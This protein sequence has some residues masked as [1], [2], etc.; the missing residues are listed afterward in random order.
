[1]NKRLLAVGGVL[2]LAL[3]VVWLARTPAHAHCDTLDG[4]VI[5]DA[6]IALEKGDVTSVLKWV[7]HANE[8]EIRAAFAKALAV[9]GKGNEARELADTYFFETLVRVHRAG[10]GAPF[11]G[12]KPAGADLGP[13]VKG[14]DEALETGKADA[15][16]ELVTHDVAEGIRARFAKVIEKKRHA[17]ESVASG[18]EYVA[19]Y[20]DYVH[21]VEGIHAATKSAHHH[22]EA[23][24]ESAGNQ[25][26]REESQPGERHE[27]HNR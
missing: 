26:A 19:A 24:A 25:H 15:L 13:A 23:V 11:T 10:E 22:G 21:F 5:A 6:R 18:R 27:H 17:T 3:G 20:V 2:G 1:M 9:R 16:V 4:P 12:L 7:T 8:G 14:A